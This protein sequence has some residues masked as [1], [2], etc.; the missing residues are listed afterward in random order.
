MSSVADLVLSVL[1]VGSLPIALFLLLVS[2][3]VVASDRRKHTLVAPVC[4]ALLARLGHCGLAVLL[5]ALVY[6]EDRT[7]ER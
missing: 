5:V 1:W 4:S 6:L 2:G 3:L 7:W